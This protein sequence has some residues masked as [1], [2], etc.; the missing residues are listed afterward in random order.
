MTTPEPQPHAETRPDT[1][2]RPADAPAPHTA[3]DEAPLDDPHV[4]DTGT[5]AG[6]A[7]ARG[8]LTEMGRLQ[9][10]ARFVT[11]G[12]L[13]FGVSTAG[14][15]VLVGQGLP[16]FLASLLAT[17]VAVI[18]NYLWHEAVTFGT[19]QVTWRRL[20]TYNLAAGVGLVITATAFALISRALP[21]VPL[22]V[23]NLLAVGCG[24][25]SNFV[26]SMRFVWGER[27]IH[28]RGRSR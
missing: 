13:G 9:R 24:T 20:V 8:E 23:R 15:W 21:D 4:P 5:A 10:L 16:D 3:S 12:V 26:L 1:A 22:V 19:K 17:E 28:R 6:I 14:L 18:H 11:V 27:I 7:T 25:T 2:A